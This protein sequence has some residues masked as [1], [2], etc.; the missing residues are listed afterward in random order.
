MPDNAPVPAPL[1]GPSDAQGYSI[2]FGALRT[3]AAAL[4]TDDVADIPDPVEPAV[5][6]EP[7]VADTVVPPVAA[8][9]V[10]TNVEGATPAQ[11]ADLPD[12]TMVKV[13]VDGEDVVM[14]WKDARAGISRNAK[15]TKN[16]QQLAQE[17]K[18]FDADKAANTALR[19]ERASLEGFLKN[20]E[21]V[22]A[23]VQR[24]FGVDP[25]AQAAPVAGNPDEIATVGSL[26]SSAA[27]QSAEFEARLAQTVQTVEQRINAATQELVHKEQTAKHAGKIDSTLAELF[28]TNPVLNVIPNAM[29]LIRY[30]VYKMAPK[31]EAEALDAF[32][33]VA[34]GMVEGLGKHFSAQTKLAKVADAKAK[35]ESKSIEPAGGTTPSLAPASYKNADGTVNWRS[36]TEAAKAFTK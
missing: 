15:F 21:A 23:Y 29:D 18:E 3:Q 5:V 14:P 12:D 27:K 11:L 32:R 6:A 28:T 9:A 4:M 10:A 13:V 26:A 19:E 25:P 31:T 22:L 30:E 33:Q 7:V 24:A 8:A 20:K 2:D 1:P 34:G 16:M 36:V 17:R 35:L